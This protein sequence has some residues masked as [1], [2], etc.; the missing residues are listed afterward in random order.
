[1]KWM[2]ARHAHVMHLYT[3]FEGLELQIVIDIKKLRE[4]ILVAPK[5]FQNLMTIYYIPK[6]DTKGCLYTLLRSIHRY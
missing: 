5:S 1:M 2:A 4:T 6:K 3:N